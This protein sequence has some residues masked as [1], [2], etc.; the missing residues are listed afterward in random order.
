[1]CVCVCVLVLGMYISKYLSNFGTISQ[2][3]GINPCFYFQTYNYIK[4]K[5]SLDKSSIK[6][7]S[8]AIYK[9]N[10]MLR[11]IVLKAH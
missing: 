10:C 7:K 1:M 11:E 9:I 4:N 3:I 5:A 6:M 8:H 2:H